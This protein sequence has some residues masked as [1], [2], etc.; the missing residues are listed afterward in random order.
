MILP[1]PFAELA[2]A[3]GAVFHDYDGLTLVETYC[4]PLTECAA[5]RAGAGVFDRSYRAAFGSPEKIG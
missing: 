2:D 3:R 4:D 1:S 5:V